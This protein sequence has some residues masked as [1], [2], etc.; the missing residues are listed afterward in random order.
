MKGNRKYPESTGN[1]NISETLS[2]EN[3]NLLEEETA[4]NNSV[5]VISEGNSSCKDT[6]IIP[7]DITEKDVDY[8]NKKFG[9]LPSAY[10]KYTDKLG[11][12]AFYIVRWDFIKD[13]QQKKETRP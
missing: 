7:P 13:N 2:E 6:S 9:C 10:Y 3:L 5:D 11:T 8:N 1:Y 12:T 4:K